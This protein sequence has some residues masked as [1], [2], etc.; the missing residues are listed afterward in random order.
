MFESLKIGNKAKASNK[1]TPV[2]PDPAIGKTH[3]ISLSLHGKHSEEYRNALAAYIRK[4]KRGNLTNDEQSEETSRLIV[5]CC[6]GW[7]GVT[8]E[9]K[10]V[11]FDR[12]KLFEILCDEDYRWMRAQADTFMAQDDNFF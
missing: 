3:G 4:T 12:K 1:F 2:H 11:K 7:E 10:D 6:D 8:E 5:A 9:G